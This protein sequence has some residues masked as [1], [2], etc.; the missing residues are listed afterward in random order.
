MLSSAFQGDTCSLA[1]HHRACLLTIASFDKGI[2]HLKVRAKS[3]V[4]KFVGITRQ[5]KKQTSA[6]TMAAMSATA[7][8]SSQR[9][10]QR[11]LARLTATADGVGK[12]RLTQV[13]HQA[14]LR[15][16]P[17]PSTSIQQ[18]GAAVCALSSYGGGM[19]PGDSHELYVEVQENATLGLL[20]QGPSRIYKRRQDSD[21]S[22]RSSLDVNVASD[23]LFVLGIDPCV[24]FQHSS[25]QQSLQVML[26]PRASCILVDWFGAG[27]LARGE[28]WSFDS[29]QSKTCLWRNGDEFPFLVESMHLDNATLYSSDDPFG[30]QDKWNA[31]CSVILHG[32]QAEPVARR[33]Q[34]LSLQL[35]N[36]YTRVRGMDSMSD[37][38]SKEPLLGLQLPLTSGR[39]LLGVNEIDVSH[40]EENFG[41]T[42]LARVAT[43]CNEDLYRILHTSL[44]P[45]APKFGIEF[46][47]DRI[48]SSQ[49]SRVQTASAPRKKTTTKQ[50]F[51]TDDPPS[52]HDN[53]NQSFNMSNASSWSA[54]MLADSGLPTG[55]FAHSAGIEAA[56]QLG[57]L[58]E[59]HA[60][61]NFV[62][63]AIRSSLQLQVPF[64]VSSQSMDT[65]RDWR[66]LDQQMHAYMVSNSVACR[67]SLEQGQ[68]L[69]RVALSWLR[70]RQSDGNDDKLQSQYVSLLEEI[71]ELVVTGEQRGHLAPIFGIVCSSLGLS[72]PDEACRLLGYCAARDMVSAAVRLNLIGPMAGVSLLDSCMNVMEEGIAG[73]RLFMDDDDDE[74]SSS[75]LS[76]VH[77]ST[78]APIVETIHPCHEILS[79]RLFRT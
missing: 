24:P 29:L 52:R 31:Y 21:L 75:V 19:L 27:R 60:L 1:C 79:V 41:P 69:L 45:L 20:T 43:T 8:S 57:L 28:F 50:T 63:A 18:A 71:H 33:L 9:W 16:V 12:T 61:R 77:A 15:L 48:H 49:T 7:S 30:F 36:E 22:C 4:A 40:G 38:V 11:G 51:E 44:Q 54:Y 37:A 25:F 65:V 78:S 46:Y 5:T 39:V 2:W 66:R 67:A 59:E 53:T 62:H 3:L 17:I 6:L 68:G 58:R 26:H 32:P 47:R 10:I 76:M 56:A 42:Y 73:A 14:P 34:D 23:A 55:S 70:E 13:S 74:E 35:A 64:V 72:S